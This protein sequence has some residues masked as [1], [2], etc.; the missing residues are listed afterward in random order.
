MSYVLVVEDEPLVRYS[1]SETLRTKKY[2]V[3]EAS[4]G[5][6]AIELLDAKNFDAVISDYRMP[7]G[8]NGLDVLFYCHFRQVRSATVKVLISALD[9]HLQTETEAIGGI[10]IRKPFLIE[11]VIRILDHALAG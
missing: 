8:V 9:S 10:Y 7:G 2:Q 3:H 11:D 5:K 1:L 6:S 4:D